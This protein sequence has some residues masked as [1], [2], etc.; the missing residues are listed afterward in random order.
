LSRIES[1]DLALI[2]LHSLGDAK[3]KNHP[4]MDLTR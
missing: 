4:C 2:L 1:R 3:L